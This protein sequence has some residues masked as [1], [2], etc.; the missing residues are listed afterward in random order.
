MGA[1]AGDYLVLSN[2][3]AL[4]LITMV[5]T[6]GTHILSGFTVGEVILIGYPK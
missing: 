5:R 4:T 3:R 6:E 1:G 2:F